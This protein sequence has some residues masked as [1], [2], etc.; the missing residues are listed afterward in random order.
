M[1]CVVLE[2]SFMESWP[3]LQ[4]DKDLWLQGGAPHV[5]VV[6]LVKWDKQSNG[7]VAGYLEIYR[8]GCATSH[9]VVS[10]RSPE[11]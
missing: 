10:T 6:L 3:K 11:P 5:N 8:R 2:V 7:Q 1:P 4:E 9:R